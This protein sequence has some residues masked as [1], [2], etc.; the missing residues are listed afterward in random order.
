MSSFLCLCLHWQEHFR[1]LKYRSIRWNH[2]RWSLLGS[3]KITEF[4]DFPPLCL[5]VSHLVT[6]QRDH[7]RLLILAVR[8]NYKFFFIFPSPLATWHR[9]CVMKK[10]SP[11][12]IF[13]A[14]FFLPS[15]EKFVDDKQKNTWK[16]SFTCMADFNCAKRSEAVPMSGRSGPFFSLHARLKRTE[17][18]VWNEKANFCGEFDSTALSA[19]YASRRQA[20]GFSYE[21]YWHKEA[22]AHYV[23]KAWVASRMWRAFYSAARNEFRWQKLHFVV[24]Y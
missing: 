10:L 18:P 3:W 19:T 11:S 22:H 12:D 13:S 9:G 23:P 14:F 15:P 20:M 24:Q 7:N 17:N 21:A 2:R 8:E 16:T 1:T 6:V 4:D 5:G